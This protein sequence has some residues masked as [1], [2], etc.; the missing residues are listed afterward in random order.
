[1]PL[2]PA[3]FLLE[4]G[5]RQLRDRKC[6]FCF[7]LLLV[8]LLSAVSVRQGRGVLCVVSYDRDKSVFCYDRDK[9]FYLLCLLQ[10][11]Q[12]CC[13]LRQGQRVLS[14]VPVT[15]GTSLLCLLR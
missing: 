4:A 14:V 3:A 2:F 7:G 13:L 10:Q 11:G 6:L 5:C 8:Q 1:M 9:V 15:T 12:V